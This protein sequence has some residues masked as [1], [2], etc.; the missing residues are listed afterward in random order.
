[1]SIKKTQSKTEQARDTGLA[2]TLLLLLGIHFFH[3]DFLLVPAIAVLVLCMAWPTFFRPMAS[4]WFGLSHIMGTVMSKVLLTVLFFLVVVP[5]SFLRR[6]AGKDAMQRRMWRKE[7]TSCM[8]V[9]NH[10]FSAED[11]KKPF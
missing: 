9:R 8:T 7:G 6:M 11:M 10:T 2:V 1:M 5:M 3:Y 4:F